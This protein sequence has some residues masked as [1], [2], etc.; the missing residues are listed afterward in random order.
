MSYDELLKKIL[1]PVEPT[2]DIK[3]GNRNFKPVR[4]LIYN[5]TIL[6]SQK[7]EFHEFRE[8]FNYYPSIY[9]GVLVTFP[10]KGE[11]YEL[12]SVKLIGHKHLGFSEVYKIVFREYDYRE[13]QEGLP[14]ERLC[15]SY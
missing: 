2:T 4:V 1:H 10:Y 3:L 13:N 15:F 9:G 14:R 12:E 11:K 8:T 5:V 7:K 6:P